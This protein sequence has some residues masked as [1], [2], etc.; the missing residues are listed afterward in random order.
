MASGRP[1]TMKTDKTAEG[2]FSPSLP[3]WVFPSLVR[4]GIFEGVSLWFS[5]FCLASTRRRGMGSLK[6][7]GLIPCGLPCVCLRNCKGC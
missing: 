5:I 2:G 6:H 4:R 3:R 1:K 7:S